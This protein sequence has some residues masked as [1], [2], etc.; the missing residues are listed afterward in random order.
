M[1][2]ETNWENVSFILSSDYRKRVLNSLSNI[3]TPTKIGKELNIDKAHISRTLSE[4]KNKGLINCLTPNS[5]KGKLYMISEYGIEMLKKLS[6]T[7]N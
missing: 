2:T 6:E 1:Q 5:R 7:F 3:K 4:L